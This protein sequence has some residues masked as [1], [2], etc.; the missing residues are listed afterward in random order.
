MISFP[1]GYYDFHSNNA[2][3]FQMNR[4]YSSGCLSYDALTAAAQQIQNFEQWTQTFCALAEQAQA[5]DDW[6]ACATYLRA[7]QFFALGDE[8]SA[9]GGLLKLDLYERC[10]A[11]YERAYADAGLQYAR[12]PLARGYLPVLYKT[13]AQNTKGAIVIHGGYD[14]FIQEFV[15]YLLYGFEHGYDVYLFEGFGQGEVLNRCGIKMRPEW[16]LCTT[17]VL[18]Y[19]GLTD[20]TLI[21]V[22]LGGYLAAR[23][24]AYE[25]RI[26]RVVLYDLIYDFYGALLAQGPAL[27]RLLINTL[28]HF[29]HSALWQPLERKMKENFFG[30]WLLRQGCYVF[31]AQNLPE[32]LACMRAYNTRTLSSKIH[33]DVLVLAGAEDMYTIYYQQQLRALIAARSVEGRVFTAEEQAAHHCQIG[34]LGLALDTIFEWIERKQSA[35]QA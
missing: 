5:Q 12:V 13:H 30:D 14:S 24:A 16:E 29:P 26:Q 19:F 18:D 32:Y 28:M 2:I 17:P 21:G 9:A 1:V 3:N 35:A 23:A 33:Q 10:M 11:A 31:G 7:A 20:V 15:P 6:V 27:N 8:R 34:N 22:S 4:W 25:P